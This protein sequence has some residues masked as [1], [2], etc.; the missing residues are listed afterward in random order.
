MI[1]KKNKK[2][3]GIILIIT[4]FNQ[5]NNFLSF[6]LEKNLIGKKKIYLIILSDTIPEKLILYFRDY[7]EK[8]AIVEVVDMRRKSI[9]FREKFFNI[10]FFKVFF[11]YFFVLKKILQIKKS[12]T[13]LYISTYSKI[14]YSILFFITFLSPSKIFIMEDGVGDYIPHNSNK[15][16]SKST[17][18]K[19]FLMLNKSRIHILQLAK[20]RTDYSGLLN[21]PYLKKE[22]Y[23]NNREIY[24]RFT[25]NSLDKKPFLK[26]KC[27]LIGTKHLPHTF[28]YYLNLYIKTLLEI[29]KKYSY[30]PEQILFFPHPRDEAIYIE[31]LEKNLSNY[32]NIATVS[33]I[34]PENYFSQN[35]LETV[36]GTLSSALYYAK[37]IFNK[38]HVSYIENF[39]EPNET[40]D[41]Y[42]GIFHSLGI[43]NFFNKL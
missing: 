11:Y 19:K 38:S 32:S 39:K 26:P 2:Q 35:N 34:V 33:S 30:S 13:I 3:E 37:S 14:Q 4:S 8:F 25:E 16:I 31:K 10:R 18:L 15:K 42:V 20:S 36:V 5:L 41:E 43:K 28:S 1:S 29:N 24:K 23:F 22:Q 12:Y 7:I 40:H 17:Y 21:E 6:F 9:K 27:I